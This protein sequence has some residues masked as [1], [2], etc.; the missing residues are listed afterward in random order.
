MRRLV[1]LILVAGTLGI[2]LG[3]WYYFGHT[4]A[5]MQLSSY[6]IGQAENF[7]QAKREIAALEH[8]S[9][10]HEALRELMPGWRTGNP[11]SDQYLATYASEPDS[12]EAFRRAFSLEL[13]WRPELLD[14]WA[15]FWSWRAKQPPSD[16]IA[17]IDDYLEALSTADPPRQLTWREVLDLQAVLTL[18]GHA[19][20]ARRIVPDNWLGRYRAWRDTNPEFSHIE[21]PDTPLP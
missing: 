15:H 5:R 1:L 16:E 2:G 9:N 19:D 4:S 18:T 11:V 13:S 20:L 7:A 17:S 12:S 10:R 3:A 14:D 6:R 21:R 8:Q